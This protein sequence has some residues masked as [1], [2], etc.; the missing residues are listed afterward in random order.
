MKF[1][2]EVAL[3]AYSE[4]RICPSEMTQQIDRTVTNTDRNN[5]ITTKANRPSGVAK[6][7]RDL[8]VPYYSVG[9]RNKLPFEQPGSSRNEIQVSGGS[10]GGR[11]LG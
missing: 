11:N 4:A 9:N 7:L 10:G 5:I 2:S 8:A 1:L 3:I 6:A